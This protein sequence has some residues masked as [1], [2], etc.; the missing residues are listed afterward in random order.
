MNN[1]S[2]YIKRAFEEIRATFIIAKEIGIV[3]A[4]DT[5]FGKLDIQILS[6][7]GYKEKPRQ[8]IRL[9][10]KHE[11]MMTYYRKK[12]DSFVKEYSLDRVASIEHKDETIWM[13]WWQG[14]E[15]APLIVQKCVESI[16]R[17]ANGR[18]VVI[19]TNDNYAEYV[20][21]PSWVIEKRKKGIITNTHFSDILRLSLL[22]KYGGLW[23]DATFY[24]CGSLDEYFNYPLWSIKRPDYLH[25]SVASGYFATYSLRCSSENRYI[26]KAILDFYLH[27]WEIEE[28]QLDYLTL[29]YMFVLVQ[30]IFEDIKLTFSLIKPNNT[31]CDNLLEL[32]N[33]VYEKDVWNNLKYD[34][35]LFKLSWKTKLSNDKKSYFNKIVNVES[36]IVDGGDR[37]E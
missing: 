24:C 32:L 15:S 21:I 23:L 19:I 31:N 17:N 36:D 16:K 10:K 34:T 6:R 13:C 11:A 9:N 14:L 27:Y 7:N 22:S 30:E 29:D 5:F 20:D 25:C 26:F 12:F 35:K 28:K 3:K 18:E 1:V 37:N 8:T 2:R 33:K 4:L